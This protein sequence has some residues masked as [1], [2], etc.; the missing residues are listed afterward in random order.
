MF[1][2]V[3]S[4]AFYYIAPMQLS[5][6]PEKQ[7]R[8]FKKL[9]HGGVAKRSKRKVAR[10]LVPGKV[11]HVVF[12]SS[13]AKGN[14]SFYKNKLLVKH[15]LKERSNKYFVEILDFVNMGNHLHLKARFK[16]LANFR[17]FLRT[18]SALLARKITKARK[19]FKFGKF[20]D[21]L[22]FTRVL[23]SAFE[24][25]GLKTY[26]AANRIERAHG[27]AAREDFLK[28]SQLFL[29]DRHVVRSEFWTKKPLP[30]NL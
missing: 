20:W 22:V 26:F 8:T 3:R 7:L 9:S 28:T 21:D 15:V 6:D 13:K 11:T 24:I 10:P 1:L 25:L 29:V 30:T 14:L 12:K 16:N 27:Y 23:T 17:N 5:L 18:F 2:V 19:G 4:Q